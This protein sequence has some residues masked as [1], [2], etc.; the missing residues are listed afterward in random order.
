MNVDDFNMYF[1]GS[2]VK[3]KDN[4]LAY[5]EHCTEEGGV[6]YTKYLSKDDASQQRKDLD[7]IEDYLVLES[8]DPKPFHSRGAVFSP[9]FKSVRGYKDG[10]NVNRLDL[11]CV[12]GEASRSDNS[13]IVDMFFEPVVPDKFGIEGIVKGHINYACLEDDILVV[14]AK[15]DTG[16][17]DK[18]PLVKISVTFD[19]ETTFHISDEVGTYQVDKADAASKFRRIPRGLT[20]VKASLLSRLSKSMSSHI[21]AW[22]EGLVPKKLID[23]NT[24]WQH[25]E[26][27]RN[28]AVPRVDVYRQGIKVCNLL[29]DMDPQ[30]VGLKRLSAKIEGL[31]ND[32]KTASRA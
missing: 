17:D 10:V 25:R 13:Y 7:T 16:E 18:E 24:A 23:A 6:V 21:P 9:S 14:K 29:E 11:N 12:R 20:T 28:K 30:L 4:M 15:P 3:T 22:G 31:K 27:E 8:F 1:S 5:V 32:Y 26:D 19:G 2:Y